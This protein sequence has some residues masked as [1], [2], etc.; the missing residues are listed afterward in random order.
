MTIQE[1]SGPWGAARV[2]ELG[3]CVLS[4]QPAGHGEV[5]FLSRDAQLT[6]GSMWH[7]GI[8]VCAPWFGQGRG[9]W[10]VPHG[11]G[12]V[13]RVPWHTET[14]ENLDDGATVVL[15]LPATQTAHLP[16][17]S[18]YPAD[19]AYRLE[20]TVGAAALTV[21]LTITS[22]TQDV[23]VDVAL[24]PYFRLNTTGTTLTG[25]EGVGFQDALRDWAT[26]TA[27]APLA[28]GEHLDLVFDAAPPLFL[29]D[30]E[31]TLRLATS[32]ANRTVVWNPGPASRELSAEWDQ[33]VCVEYGNVREGA[34][35]IP[36][37]GAHTMSMTVEL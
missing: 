14:V 36:A 23:T 15:T 29:S 11:H 21:A 33:F 8:P 35:T 34:I 7:G 5:L 12:L 32:S 3:G 18:R 17:A 22:P 24:H 26:G 30:G 4:W 19:L 25:L 28:F 13:S 10:Q 27:E 1:L 9:D 6:P 31:T 2:A 16:G 37:G 20:I